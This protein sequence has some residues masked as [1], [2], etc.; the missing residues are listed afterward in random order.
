MKVQKHEPDIIDEALY[1][2]LTVHV[3]LRLLSTVPPTAA[4]SSEIV[5]W[6]AHL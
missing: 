4:V 5:V 2:A 6:M 1:V 3:E